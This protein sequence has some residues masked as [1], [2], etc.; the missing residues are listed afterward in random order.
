MPSLPEVANFST[1][2]FILSKVY[3]DENDIK[4]LNHGLFA[5]TVDNPL[6]K[7]RGLPPCTGKQTMVYLLRT[8][9]P[10]KRNILLLSLSKLEGQQCSKDFKELRQKWCTYNR[11]ILFYSTPIIFNSTLSSILEIIF[12]SGQNKDPS[13]SAHQRRVTMVFTFGYSL[14]VVRHLPRDATFITDAWN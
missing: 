11:E 5:R 1:T 12:P 8:A 13:Q 2:Y 10:C 4:C 3:T 14:Y 7:A 9:R 6:A